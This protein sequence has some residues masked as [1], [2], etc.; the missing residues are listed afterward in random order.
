MTDLFSSP[1]FPRYTSPLREE[2]TN[3]SRAEN[4]FRTKR[5]RRPE[6]DECE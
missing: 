2:V 4:T 5:L 3:M 6:N 1:S